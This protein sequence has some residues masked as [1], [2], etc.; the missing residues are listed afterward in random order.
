MDNLFKATKRESAVDIVVNSIKQLLADKKLL[1]GD[2]LP[3]ELEISEGLGV[4]RGSVREAMK[5][6]SAFGLI[7]I[8]VGNGTYVSDSPSSELLD[9]LLF[10]YFITN[11]DLTSL[12]EFR[13]IFE[14]DIVRL[15]IDHYDENQEQR[16][17]LRENLKELDALIQ[18]GAAPEKILKNDMDFH[19]I[20]GEASCNALASRIYY[21]VMD[22]FRASISHTH[23][24]Q[25]GEYVYKAHS[26]IYHIIESKAYD[27][28][29]ECIKQTIDIW[30]D[31]LQ[32]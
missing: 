20:L 5:I 7:D 1:P 29:E 30:Y 6:L 25:N 28:I 9:S 24:H 10:T 23:K 17:S 16:N 11:P 22:S 2:K 19:H 4:S 15:A 14:T 32:D 3:N 18:E 13:R 12:Y 26:Q 31:L 21:F 27:D 8:R